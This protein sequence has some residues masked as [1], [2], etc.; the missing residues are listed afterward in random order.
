MEQ[1]KCFRAKDRLNRRPDLHS[2]NSA[3]MSEPLTSCR[4]GADPGDPLP[5][6]LG[7]FVRWRLLAYGYTLA[8]FY[9]ACLVYV[10]WLGVWLVNASGAPL[11]H[12]FTNIW[13]A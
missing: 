10:Y 9:A 13:V 11:Y 8:A 4:I 2:L 5:G 12:D 6:L 3:G 7:I 1:H